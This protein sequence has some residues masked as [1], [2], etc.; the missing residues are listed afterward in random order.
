MALYNKEYTLWLAFYKQRQINTPWAPIFYHLGMAI[1]V[2]VGVLSRH[3][4][5]YS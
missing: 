5:D 2:P 3:S 1:C 4:D